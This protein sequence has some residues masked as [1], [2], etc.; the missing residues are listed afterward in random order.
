[1]VL[2]KDHTILPLIGMLA[3]LVLFSQKLL[4]VPGSRTPKLPEL[5]LACVV[6]LGTEFMS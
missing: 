5:C 2:S 4:Q 1:M 3:H 6:A